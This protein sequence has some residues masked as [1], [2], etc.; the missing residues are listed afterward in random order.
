VTWALGSLRPD[1]RH[2]FAG[3]KVGQQQRGTDRAVFRGHRDPADQPEGATRVKAAHACSV[4]AGK[5]LS[6]GWENLSAGWENLSA[7]WENLTEPGRLR[8]DICDCI[9]CPVRKLI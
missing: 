9:G 7:G 6:A 8:M 3:Y 2:S 4:L 5:N 1:R